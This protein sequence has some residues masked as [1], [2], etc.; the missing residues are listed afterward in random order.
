[1]QAVFHNPGLLYGTLLLLQG[2]LV[3]IQL[4]LLAHMGS[5]WWRA[6]SLTLMLFT[7]YYT[8]FKA[9]RDTVVSWRLSSSEKLLHSK[10]AAG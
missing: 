4:G 6:L 7:N 1:M 8:L 10:L 5:E 9:T 2:L 3:F